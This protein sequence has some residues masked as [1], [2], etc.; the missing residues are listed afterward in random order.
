MKALVSSVEVLGSGYRIV[1]VTNTTFAVHEPILFWVDCPD[2]CIVD[3]WFFDHSQNSCRVLAEDSLYKKNK[4][5]GL[6]QESD[7]ASYPDVSNK[8]NS[9]YLANQNE[10]QEYRN[11]LRAIFVSSAEGPVDWPV[12]PEVIWEFPA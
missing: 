1:E 5:L 7:W 2:E 10:F 11:Q 8:L 3:L 6:L 9:P 4:S 12:I